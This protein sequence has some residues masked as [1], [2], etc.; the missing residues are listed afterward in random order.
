MVDSKDSTSLPDLTRRTLLSGTALI[1]L[2]RFVGLNSV[3]PHAVDPVATLYQEWVLAD[4]EAMWWCRRSDELEGELF[5]SIGYPRVS[6]LL[7]DSSDMVWVSAHT[8]ID[9]ILENMPD[10][11]ILR[12]QLHADL[13]RRQALWDREAAFS[14]LVEAE[15]QEAVAWERR[16]SLATR[17]LSLPTHSLSNVVTKLTLILRMGE[18]R[19]DDDEFPWSQINSVLVDLR[20]LMET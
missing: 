12:A 10:S 7:S 15:R 4:A 14:G 11:E 8:D 13:D 5:R 3:N 18:E 1:P 20:R 16:E 2:A 6:I 19:E 17:A 9:R